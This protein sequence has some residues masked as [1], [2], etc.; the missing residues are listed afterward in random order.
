MHFQL[1]RADNGD[2]IGAAHGWTVLQ[3]DGK[4]STSVMIDLRS[5]GGCP[6]G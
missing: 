6:A 3:Y 4:P 1:W 2:T 5:G